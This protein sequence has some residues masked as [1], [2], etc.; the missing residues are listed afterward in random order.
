MKRSRIET[1]E[2]RGFA[3]GIALAVAILARMHDLPTVAADIASEAGFTI[4]DYKR[5]KVDEYDLR[6]LRKLRR[7]EPRFPRARRRTRQ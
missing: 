7:E 4:A 2:D 3:Q 1:D 6:A 5:A